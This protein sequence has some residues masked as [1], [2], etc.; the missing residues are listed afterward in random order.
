MGATTQNISNIGAGTYTL[1]V[2]DGAN[3]TKSKSTT[4]IQSAAM[5]ASLTPSLY[6]GGYNISQYNGSNGTITPGVSGGAPPYSYIWNNGSTVANRIGLS[7]GSYS[8]TV[9]DAN[10][11]SVQQSKTLTQPTAL[12]ISSITSSTHSGYNIS[13]NGGNNGNINISVTGGV[14]PYHYQWSNGSFHQNLTDLTAGDYSVIVTDTNN[15]SK[16]GSLTLTQPTA[17]TITS[18]LSSYPDDYNVSCYHCYNGSITNTVTGGITPY[19]YLW[20]GGQ[21]TL[22]RSTLGGG[23]YQLSVT[24]GNG[25][26]KQ[27]TSSLTEPESN[28]WARSGN[29]ETDPSS[30]FI[31]TTDTSS[32]SFRTNNTEAMRIDKNGKIGIGTDNPQAK[33]DLTGDIKVSTLSFDDG[34]TGN[35]HLLGTGHDGIIRGI[36][37]PFQDMGD[38][39]APGTECVQLAVLP[40]YKPTGLITDFTTDEDIVKWPVEG[41]LGIGMCLPLAK[42]DVRTD[43]PS[44]NTAAFSVHNNDGEALA[45]LFDNGQFGIGVDYIPTGYKLAVYGKIICE[46]LKVKLY[47]SG[48]PDDVFEKTYKPMSLSDLEHFIKKNKHLPGIPSAQEVSANDGFNVGELQTIMLKKIEE[49]TLYVIQLQKEIDELKAR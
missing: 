33:L 21:T 6:Y 48:W 1:T 32:I 5:A 12:S 44:G 16:S 19:T 39:G 17:I 45:I 41:N 8:V 25:C 15:A 28:D 2:T 46:E 34:G 26:I 27:N 13:C 47:S 18:T 38:I 7:A 49:L 43:Y 31:G 14:P 29:A 22:N 23:A 10:S 42:L 37:L 30:N 40:W 3:H 4:L 35:I 36:D 20:S 11:C 24:D 9:T